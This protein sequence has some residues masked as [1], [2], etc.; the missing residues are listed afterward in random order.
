MRV[1]LDTNVFIAA[2]LVPTGAA[3]RVLQAWSEGRF[4]LLYSRELIL[5]LR[6]VLA[7]PRLRERVKRH[8]VGA[9]VRRIRA[10]GERVYNNQNS[11][12]SVDPKDDFLMAIAE[13]GAADY[14]VSRDSEGVLEIKLPGVQM[15]TPEALLALLFAS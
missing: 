15:L 13:H 1:V 3:A 2:L 11:V 5:E 6:E 12:E 14:L 7:R 8:R 9:L 10:R 4:V